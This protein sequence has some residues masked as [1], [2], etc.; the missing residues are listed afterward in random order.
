MNRFLPLRFASRRSW[1][2]DQRQRRAG[3]SALEQI[4]RYAAIIA[5]LLTTNVHANDSDQSSLSDTINWHGFLSQGFTYTDENNF[6]G[7]SSDGSFKFNEAGLNASWRANNQLQFS[8]QALYKQI[9][10]AEPKGI[11][12]DHAIADW[13]VIDTFD[14]GAGL[15]A[16]RLKNPYGFYNETRDTAATRPSI[17]L[18]ESIYIDYL[19]AVLHSSDSVGIYGH[20][21]LKTGTL[22]FSAVYGK[23]ILNDQIISV[24]INT[25]PG[26]PTRGDIRDELAKAYRLDYEDASGQ[27]RSAISYIIFDGNFTPGT[28]EPYS[29]GNIRNEQ[30]LF[31][32]ELNWQDWQLVGEYQIRETENNGILAVDFNKK[33]TG[34]YV[35]LGYHFTSAL[36]GYFRKDTVFLDD[37]DKSGKKLELESGGAFFARDAF[38]KDYTLGLAYQPSFEWSFGIELHHVNGTFWLPDLE[39]PD[40]INQEKRWNMLL[41]QA[42]YRF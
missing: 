20:Q 37:S 36:K 16:G 17:L 9:G 5:V 32:A 34:Y 40:V 30:L 6:L 7:S 41:L 19:R 27:W 14:F 38:A 3:G 42:A 18:P 26:V 39:N 2:H 22:S 12:L 4:P 13:R 33:G 25:Y 15:R 29:A 23:P 8:A 24:L 1:N 28:G 11:Q 35:Q 10:N 31:S 21:E